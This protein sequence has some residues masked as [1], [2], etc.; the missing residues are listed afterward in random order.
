MADLMTFHLPATV[1]GT[2]SDL[3]LGRAMIAAWR[4]DGIFQVAAD[5]VQAQRI[6]TA[7]AAGRRFFSLPLEYKA[8]HVSDLSYSG[9]LV[10]GGEGAAVEADRS[11][12]FTVCKDVPAGDARVREGWP[13][14]GPV[15][16]PDLEYRLAMRAF[17]DVAGGIGERL[18]RLVAL[19][20]GLPAMDGLSRLTRDGWH[21][22]RVLRVPARSA[23]A[24]RGVGAHTGYGLV[25]IAA[26]DEAGGLYVRPP[27]PGEA[28]PRDL[29]EAEGG[30]VMD[31]HEPWGLV[32]P[33]PGVL[34]VF[35]GDI[36][37]FLTGGR[38]RSAPH[39]IALADRER[40]ALIY[41]HEPGF[42]TVLRPLDDPA[43]DAVHYGTYFTDMFTRCYP[44]RAAT[45]RIQKEGG[46][47][48]LERL[49]HGALPR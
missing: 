29:P 40:Y 48:R 32:R 23:H 7:M 11:E 12:S 35:P 21:H 17:M 3:D 2:P 27:V 41:V 34:T 49:R 22:M 31:E 15:P 33:A 42:E 5:A 45:L 26:Q 47:E 25:A 24:R 6:V 38:L 1:R 44:D 18:L 36:M 43:G 30:A 16:W 4:A 10:R 9:Y 46:Q 14:H 39:K 13:C 37:Q 20:L 8:R 19:G 28:R